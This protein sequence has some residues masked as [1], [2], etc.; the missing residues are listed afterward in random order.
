MPR[1]AARTRVAAPGLIG[2]PTDPSTRSVDR[3]CFST[4]PAPKRMSALSRAGREGRGWAR[5][6]HAVAHALAPPSLTGSRSARCRTASPCA[7]GRCVGPAGAG[8][9]GHVARRI[10]ARPL[11]LAAPHSHVPVAARVGVEWRRLKQER[12]LGRGDRRGE[13]GRGP[14]PQR[15]HTPPPP[16]SRTAPLDSGPYRTYECPVIQPQSAMHAYT[17]PG[18]TSNTRACVML[19]VGGVR[20]RVGAW[21]GVVRASAT[22]A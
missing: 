5:G 14:R 10:L 4:G 9:G 7:A 18:R 8:R 6:A 19:P 3:S 21:V 17:S 11:P 15:P 1:T 2:S 16:M 12:R 20:D 22:R 13:G